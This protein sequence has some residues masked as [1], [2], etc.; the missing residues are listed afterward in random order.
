[1]GCRCQDV[2]DASVTELDTAVVSPTALPACRESPSVNRLVMDWCL[3]VTGRHE[4]AESSGVSPSIY[5]LV[6]AKARNVP[7]RENG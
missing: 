4:I 5:S 2:A 1:M 6:W 3:A 7:D